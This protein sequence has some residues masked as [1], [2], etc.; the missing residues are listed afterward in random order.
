MPQNPDPFVNVWRNEQAIRNAF[1]K[2][3]FRCINIYQQI[4]PQSARFLC[5]SWLIPLGKRECTCS[6][7]SLYQQFWSEC[8]KQWILP[9][10]RYIRLGT[11]RLLGLCMLP[12]I[13]NIW[14]NV[15]YFWFYTCILLKDGLWLHCKPTGCCSALSQTLTPRVIIEGL[16]PEIGVWILQKSGSGERRARSGRHVQWHVQWEMQPCEYH[17][18]LFLIRIISKVEMEPL[19]TP[20]WIRSYYYS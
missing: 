20:H 12:K 9:P 6:I 3:S 1:G 13:N 2:L 4:S 7:N 18:K 11:I 15:I 19:T 16:V 10:M 5:G 17:A 14:F 8:M